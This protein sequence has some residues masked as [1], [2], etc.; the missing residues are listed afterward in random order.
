[1]RVWVFIFLTG[2]ENGIGFYFTK[3]KHDQITSP[4]EKRIHLELVDTSQIS[5]NIEKL[6]EK[7]T[8]KYGKSRHR[9]AEPGDGFVMVCNSNF[10]KVH[11]CT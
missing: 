8:K 7:V 3:A 5:N 1:M 11:F 10:E 2:L 9:T 6:R 4:T